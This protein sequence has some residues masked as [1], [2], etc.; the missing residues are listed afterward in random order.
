[1]ESWMVAIFIFA[2]V[3]VGMAGQAWASWLEHKRRTQAMD[4]I[5]TALQAGREPARELYDVVGG[6][7]GERKPPWSEVVV[8]AALGA[9][10]WVAWFVGDEGQK[11]RFLVIAV[12]MSVAAVGCL[13]YALWKGRQLQRGR[14][15]DAE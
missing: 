15:D 2:A 12:S 5:K 14:P 10:F 11:W 3:A 13:A 8:F 6:R 4:V 9:A 1:M 7:G